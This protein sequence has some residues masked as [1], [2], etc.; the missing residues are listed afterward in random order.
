MSSRRDAGRS[1]LT[2][3]PP[4]KRILAGLPKRQLARL[5]PSLERVTLE[6]KDVL[7]DPDKPVKHVYFP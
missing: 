2:G 6:S 7:F 5:T 3:A 1:S 4:R